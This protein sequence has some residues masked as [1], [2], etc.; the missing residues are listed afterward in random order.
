RFAA[1]VE[2]KIVQLEQNRVDLIFEINEGP[3]TYVKGINFVGNRV[4]SDSKLREVLRTKESRWYRFFSSDD[5]FDPDR[6]TF[7]RELLR[8]YYLER[9]YADF[10][11]VSAVAE[12][13]P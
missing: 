2:P 10:S 4:Y 3:A 12:L 8:R 6:M 1:T 7:D 11:V 9:G 13:T 5:T